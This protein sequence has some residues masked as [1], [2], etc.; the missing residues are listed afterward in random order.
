MP[1][2]RPAARATTPL[3]PSAPTS[4]SAWTRIP[5]HRR[6][7]PRSFELDRVDADTVAE[8]GSSCR[9][10][11][12]QVRIEATPLRHQD[13]RRLAAAAERAAEAESE[14]ERVHGVLDDRGDVT[15][16]LL[17]RPARETTAARL[18]AREPGAV[19]EQHARS[20]ARE[21]ECGGGTG[22]PGADDE[23]VVAAHDVIVGTTG[24]ARAPLGALAAAQD[25]DAGDGCPAL[26]AQTDEHR[27]CIVGVAQLA[28]PSLRVHPMDEHVE[29]G[30][31]AR[32]VDVLAVEER[33]V[34]IG[35]SDRRSLLDPACLRVAGG[36]VADESLGSGHDARDAAERGPS[37]RAGRSRSCGPGRRRASSRARRSSYRSYGCR[38]QW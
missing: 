27:R 8:L 32:D 23:D 26:P 17:E 38:C 5:A 19:G 9:R 1:G 6:L 3:A 30:G 25:L 29:A 33:R 4:T 24:P 28:N 7:D 31:E 21:A 2:S 22:R 11:L 16:R 36:A 18:V 35:V 10:L 12:G 14:L 15:G 20:P 37:G 34:A 13:Q